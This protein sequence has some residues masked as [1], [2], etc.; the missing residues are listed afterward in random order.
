MK[1]N[2]K[3]EPLR[4]SEFIRGIIILTVLLRRRNLSIVSEQALRRQ[5]SNC[6]IP[7]GAKPRAAKKIRIYT[8]D[9]YINR[10]VATQEI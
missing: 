5:A 1:R 4:K 9:N 7:T 3:T 2:S 10:S 8:G 6:E